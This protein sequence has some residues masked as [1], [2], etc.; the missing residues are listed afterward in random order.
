M[1]ISELGQGTQTWR[2]PVA[3]TLPSTAVVCALIYRGKY[4]WVS[5]RK[6]K[7]KKIVDGRYM[8]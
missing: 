6:N 8:V 5:Y 1:N 4:A 3:V 7:Y 2:V